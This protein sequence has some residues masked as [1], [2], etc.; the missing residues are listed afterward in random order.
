MNATGPLEPSRWHHLGHTATSVAVGFKGVPAESSTTTRTACT[1]PG[2]TARPSRI[3]ASPDTRQRPASYSGLP[4]TL[5][6]P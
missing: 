3:S 4:A 2:P 5:T 6:R 1:Y